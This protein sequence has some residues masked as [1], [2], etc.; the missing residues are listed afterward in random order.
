MAHNKAKHFSVMG[1]IF[2]SKENVKTR[3]KGTGP[4][5]IKK[6]FTYIFI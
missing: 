6:W 4:N 1:K 3:G 2:P 5:K